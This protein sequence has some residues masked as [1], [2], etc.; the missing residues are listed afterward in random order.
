MLFQRVLSIRV[1]DSGS[2]YDMMEDPRN[3]SL[4]SPGGARNPEDTV[5]NSTS[6]LQCFVFCVFFMVILVLYQNISPIFSNLE[7][8]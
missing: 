8:L 2:A 4:V 6:T 3:M 5:V 1:G 7:Y